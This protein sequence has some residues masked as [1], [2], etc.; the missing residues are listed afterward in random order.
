MQDLKLKIGGVLKGEISKVVSR[1]VRRVQRRKRK[2]RRGGKV[3]A[4]EK[5]DRRVGKKTGGVNSK[6]GGA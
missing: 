4:V 2:N 5:P 1:Y 6:G 3:N